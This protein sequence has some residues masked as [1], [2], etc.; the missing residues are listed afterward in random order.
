MHMMSPTCSSLTHRREELGRTLAPESAL[1]CVIL[2]LLLLVLLRLLL[3][4]LS[5]LLCS[6]GLGLLSL[7]L[8]PTLDG[9][10]LGLGIL[11]CLGNQRLPSA[12]YDHI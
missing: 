9:L 7:V 6:L 1:L 2:V 5:L 8:L 10:R 12:L 4:P 11:L 3:A